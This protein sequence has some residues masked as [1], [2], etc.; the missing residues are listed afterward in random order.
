MPVTVRSPR[1]AGQ[2][3]IKNCVATWQAYNTWGGYDLYAGPGSNYGTRSLAVSLDRP[4]DLG[5]GHVPPYKR[6]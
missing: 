1:T 2:V 3:V 6:T 4:Y 5:D